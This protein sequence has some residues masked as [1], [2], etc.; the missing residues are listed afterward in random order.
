[1]IAL[2]RWLWY[3]LILGRAP[4]PVLPPHRPCVCGHGVNEYGAAG[5]S[6]CWRSWCDCMVY[7]KDGSKA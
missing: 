3:W 5:T 6:I 1:M 7:V 2:V 4:R